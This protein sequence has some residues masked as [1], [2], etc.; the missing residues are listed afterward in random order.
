MIQINKQ[1]LAILFSILILSHATVG[2]IFYDQG[3]HQ[4]EIE[5]L[6]AVTAVAAVEFDLPLNEQKRLM[7]RAVRVM[8]VKGE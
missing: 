2:G 1:F 3:K 4:G 5:A 7:E 6:T 8:K